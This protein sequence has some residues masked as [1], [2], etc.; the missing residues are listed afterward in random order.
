MKKI[1][2]G[3]TRH[4]KAV[5]GEDVSKALNGADGGKGPQ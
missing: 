2:Q 5:H 4:L 3:S 1:S